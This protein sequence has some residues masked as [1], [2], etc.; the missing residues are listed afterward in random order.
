MSDH[1]T[2]DARALMGTRG[3]REAE[4]LAS[5]QGFTGPELG[6]SLQEYCSLY[7]QAGYS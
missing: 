4:T 7:R 5:P 2:A 6:V 3:G 1:V